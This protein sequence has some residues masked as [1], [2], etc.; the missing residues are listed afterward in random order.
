MQRGGRGQISVEY[1]MIVG[2]MLVVALGLLGTSMFYS[3]HIESVVNT[4]QVDRLAR[5]IVDTAESV[6]FYGVPSKST[7]HASIPKGVTAVTISPNELS[8]TVRSTQGTTDINYVSSVQLQ[9]DIDPTAGLRD[10]TVEA[11]VGFVWINGTT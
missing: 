8:F 10:I 3:R 5:Q 6:Y 1:L 2:V 4:N 11:R 7:I 9:G